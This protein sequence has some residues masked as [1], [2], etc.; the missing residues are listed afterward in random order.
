[1]KSEFNRWGI[2]KFRKI[3]GC[4]Q[5]TGGFGLLA[6]FY[7]PLMT[8][9]SSLGLTVL[10]LLGFILRLIVKDGI[11]KSSPAFIYI[12]INLIILLNNL[13]IDF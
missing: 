7:F 3:V 4:A 1:M 10:M 6:G 2:S 12:I 8:V 9:L 11:I 5:L 13:N